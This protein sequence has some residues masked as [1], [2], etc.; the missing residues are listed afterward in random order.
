MGNHGQDLNVNGSLQNVDDAQQIRL[1]G[2]GTE[3]GETSNYA[4]I[5]KE[6]QD[7]EFKKLEGTEIPHNMKDVVKEYFSDY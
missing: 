4:D 1:K 2:F 7:N 5:V 6:Y 3:A